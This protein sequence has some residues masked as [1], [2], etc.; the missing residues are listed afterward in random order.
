MCIYHDIIIISKVNNITPMPVLNLE[1]TA[2]LATSAY[3][4]T[5][6]KHCQV[7][8]LFKAL[9]CAYYSGVYVCYFNNLA[10]KAFIDKAPIVM[11]V[12]HHLL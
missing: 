2:M 3:I 12:T 9:V 6:S 7:T 1:Q 8:C 5:F 4:S 11:T 10:I